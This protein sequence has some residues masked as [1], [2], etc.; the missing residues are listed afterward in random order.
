MLKRAHPKDAK[1]QLI[2]V[3]YFLFVPLQ[4]GR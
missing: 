1:E 3:A 4:V 2:W